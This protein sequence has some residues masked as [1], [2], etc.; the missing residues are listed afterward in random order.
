MGGPVSL[1]MM[2]G[3][4]RLPSGLYQ[5]RVYAAPLT[6][7]QAAWF[8]HLYSVFLL[9]PDYSGPL[10][11]LYRVSDGAEQDFY[12]DAVTGQVYLPG[13]AAWAGASGALVCRLY[14]QIGD[15]TYLEQTSVTNMP[16]FDPAD[17]TCDC[18]EADGVVR[19]LV[20]TGL[21]IAQPY[22]VF[23][24]GI[25]TGGSA[26]AQVALNL[27]AANTPGGI[28]LT[29][30]SDNA[31]ETKLATTSLALIANSS[32]GTYWRTHS[33]IC[34]GTS[35]AQYSSWLEA[36][37]SVLSTADTTTCDVI[38]VGGKSG[39]N[40]LRWQGRFSSVLLAPS[41]LSRED[42]RTV[43]HKLNLMKGDAFAGLIGAAGTYG[44]SVARAVAG[45]V[46]TPL[47][48]L[49]ET[50]SPDRQVVL[51]SDW[52][53]FAD[54]VVGEYCDGWGVRTLYNQQSTSGTGHATQTDRTKQP[55]FNW[56]G[57]SN[58]T[59]TGFNSMTF[60]GVDDHLAVPSLT[61]PALDPISFH[62]LLKAHGTPPSADQYLFACGAT[63]TTG[64]GFLLRANSAANG[65]QTGDACLF[66]RGYNS[67]QTAK[68]IYSNVQG[69]MDGTWRA[70]GGRRGSS[71]TQNF[72][73]T[74]G[75]A[76]SMTERSESNVAILA[77]TDVIYIG[78][79]DA[80]SGFY[81][82]DLVDLRIGQDANTNTY[83]RYFVANNQGLGGMVYS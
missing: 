3:W 67:G 37:Q 41:A 45:G 14:N 44:W 62:A 18:D 2:H 48:L 5:P 33:V 70:V 27:V 21:S 47:A 63:G 32:R 42:L 53:G 8:S 68:W 4:K 10:M 71:D 64:I 82:G 58:G 16:V 73:S 75:T 80:A 38:S 74:T 66:G 51:R 30:T 13:V 46:G 54:D 25:R 79:L 9:S 6:S 50:V 35:S 12:A 60:D 72:V 34:N 56:G 77:V 7:V 59:L 83:W 40:T 49:E 76:N 29:G 36:N 52:R 17:G 28:G 24:Q 81:K 26:V 65:W 22:T 20:R 23:W 19:Y 55:R 11:R 43:T 1:S 69:L 39:S 15:G 57:G 31:L 78:S 61:F